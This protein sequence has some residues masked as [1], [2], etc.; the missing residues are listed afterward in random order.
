MPD[1]KLQVILIL[2]HLKL[3]TTSTSRFKS[4]IFAFLNAGIAIKIIDFKFPIKKTIGLGH[5]LATNKIETEIEENHITIK[6]PLNLIQILAFYFLNNFNYPI[7]KITNWVHQFIYGTD[8]FSPDKLDISK[9]KLT[10]YTR[11]VVIVFGGP[12]GIF[13]YAADLSKAIEAKLILDYRDP[14]T[15]G[16]TP[17]DAN[18]FIYKLN[19]LINRK[20]EIKILNQASLVTTVSKSLKNLFPK[21]YHHK[22][23]LF[24]NGSNFNNGDVEVNTKF[25]TFNIVYAGTIYNDQLNENVFFEALNLFLID[26]EKEK[27]KL[28]FIGSSDNRKLINIIEEFDLIKVC[29]ITPRL[30][31]VELK[32]YL[33][34]AYLFLHLRFGNRKDIIS[35]KQSDYLF[36]R[37]PILLPISDDGDLSQSIIKN[38]AGYVCNTVEEN[39]EVLNLLWVNFN[40][41]KVLD[42][43]NLI[44]VSK[45]ENRE[46][47]AKEFVIKV[48]S[49]S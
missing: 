37:K 39:I 32:T 15:F 10:P 20:R 38:N 12:F 46:F 14:W 22:I 1:R 42:K 30:D 28:Q 25:K 49:I 33:N 31:D 2:P 27:F 13:K 48:E 4:I 29:E 43:F 26:K 34:E 3:N 8:V 23:E 18:P 5:Q 7:W 21:S 44:N 6:P 19:Q 45:C 17:L 40:N 16:Y 47:I 36:F 11:N 9:L 41:Q 24:E 35:T